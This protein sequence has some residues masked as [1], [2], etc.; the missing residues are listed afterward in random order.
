MIP[1]ITIFIFCEGQT[2][3]TFVRDILTEHFQRRNI[4][5]H[6][7]LNMT[8]R[9]RRG[10]VPTYGKMQ[11]QVRRQCLR[12]PDSWVTTML[13]YYGLPNDF[14]GKE[15][16][17]RRGD[18]FTRATHVEQR[19]QEDI[20]CS[21]FIAHMQ[22][23]EFEGLLFSGPDAFGLTSDAKFDANAIREL[24]R[25]RDRFRTPEHINDD[26]NTAPSK[27]IERVCPGYQKRVHGPLI[28]RHIGLDIIREQCHH[29]NAWLQKLEWLGESADRGH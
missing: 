1:G 26:P 22:I 18:S 4:K 24:K 15:T 21:N 17:P 3:E 9:T 2:E 8:G 27:R 14:P 29:F 7:I 25:I 10:G 12:H 16:I 11:R 28:A 19:F 6:P 23:H 13:D 5:L 20:G